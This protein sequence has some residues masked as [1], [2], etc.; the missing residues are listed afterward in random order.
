MHIQ[1]LKCED[2]SILLITIWERGEKGKWESEGRKRVKE[3]RWRNKRKGEEKRGKRKVKRG[4]KDMIIDS[5]I[6][7]TIVCS[8]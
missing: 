1:E 3:E 8:T 7:T 5:I 6:V 2:L 4:K